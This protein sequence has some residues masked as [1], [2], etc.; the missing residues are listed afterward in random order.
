MDV[1][2]NIRWYQNI[3]HG[4]IKNIP[5]LEQNVE[6]VLI[7]ILKWVI[8]LPEQGEKI[9]PYD[10]TIKEEDN[11]EIRKQIEELEELKEILQELAGKDYTLTMKRKEEK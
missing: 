5:D 6:N 4:Q 8:E 3:G 7:G 2:K 11:V 9:M 10:L 1:M